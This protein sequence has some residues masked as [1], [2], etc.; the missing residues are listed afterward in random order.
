[1]DGVGFILKHLQFELQYAP[2]AF[3]SVQCLLIFLPWQKRGL[4]LFILQIFVSVYYA[5]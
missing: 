2:V 3:K 1:M 4:F 5:G